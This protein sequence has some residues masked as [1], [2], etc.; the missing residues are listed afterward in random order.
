MS[1]LPKNLRG[2][3]FGVGSLGEKK[4][5]EPLDYVNSLSLP[6]TFQIPANKEEDMIRQFAVLIDGFEE[7][8]GFLWEPDIN[9]YR[10]MLQSHKPL[11]PPR[12]NFPSLYSMCEK[13]EYNIIKTQITA[14]VTMAYNIRSPDGKKLVSAHLLPFFESLMSRIGQ[15]ISSHLE[16][17][18][19]EIVLCQDDPSMAFILED[20]KRETHQEFSMKNLMDSVDNTYPKDIIPAYHYCGDWRVAHLKED[21]LLWDSTPKIVHI[22]LINYT[23]EISNE[24]AEKINRFIQRGGALA[25]GVIPNTDDGIRGSVLQDLR[26]NLRLTIDSFQDAGVETDLLIS[27]SMISTQCGLSGASRELTRK[28]H[29]LSDEYPAILKSFS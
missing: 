24:H 23:P 8:G 25:L 26:T 22:D 21:Y 18:S 14:P 3:F 9:V 12:K 19:N 11:L 6:Y 10:E 4:H 29:H 16:N 15:G 5:S 28:V 27:S 20:I 7:E 13:R 17:C 2:E 1:R